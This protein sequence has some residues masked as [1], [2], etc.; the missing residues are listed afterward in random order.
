MAT[1]GGGGSGDEGYEA[2][3]VRQTPKNPALQQYILLGLEHLYLAT[4]LAT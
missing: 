4:Y 1:R 3:E 2:C